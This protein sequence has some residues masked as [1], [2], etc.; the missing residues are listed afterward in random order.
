MKNKIIWAIDPHE[1]DEGSFINSA[2]FLQRI[3]R[4]LKADVIPVSV[5][6]VGLF[7]T[8][9]DYLVP[10]VL[11]EFKYGTTQKLERWSKYWKGKNLFKPHVLIDE[12]ATLSTS[13]QCLINFAKRKK[14]LFIFLTTHARTGLPR[15]WLGSFVETLMMQSSVPVLTTSPKTK[16]NLN[17]SNILFPT[18]LSK[19]SK[20]ALLDFLP[21]AK[22][23]NGRITLAHCFREFE[24]ASKLAPEGMSQAIWGNYQEELKRIR[25]HKLKELSK[26]KAL[27]RSK[28]LSCRT[29][30]IEDKGNLAQN[31]LSV[32]D[33]NRISL[34]ALASTS[35]QLENLFTGGIARQLTRYSPCPVWVSHK[36]G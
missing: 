30:V 27:V 4:D 3:A 20:N 1:N 22:A 8:P 26:L 25:E 24:L 21:V 17:F 33:E 31:I 29:E 15:F 2:L 18:D 13:A 6:S 11:R 16:V 12:A 36:G 14:A 10:P 23:L 19:S 32:L 34:V 5:L 7:S 9:L 35:G 28:G